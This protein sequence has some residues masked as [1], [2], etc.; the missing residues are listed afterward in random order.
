M[1]INPA[2]RRG[3][4]VSVAQGVTLGLGGNGRMRGVPEIGNHVFIGRN[5]TIV[6]KVRVGN[7]CVSGANNLLVTDVPDNQSVVGVPAR[8]LAIG[9]S[10]VPPPASDA[11]PA[12]T[13]D[14]P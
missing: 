9:V 11:A 10:P 14:Q 6:S 8:V 4:H 7:G 12:D 2:V 13:P 5:S 1:W 3:H